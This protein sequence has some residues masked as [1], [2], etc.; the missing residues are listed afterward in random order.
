MRRRQ[1]YG[2]GSRRQQSTQDTKLEEA[3]DSEKQSN[4]T[5]QELLD[6]VPQNSIDSYTDQLPLLEIPTL[7]Q[8][9]DGPHITVS[10]KPEDEWPPP[11]YTWPADSE[12]KIK[13]AA[14]EVAVKAKDYAEDPEDLYQ[15]YRA[16]PKPRAPY[17][18]ARL[19]HQFLRHLYIVERKDESSM[20]RYL[21]VLDDV[22]NSAIPLTTAE[23]NSAISFA[24]RYVTKSTETEAE[25]ALY[26]FKEMEQLAGIKGN[27]TTFN[28]LFDVASKA[29]RFTLAE[30]IYKEMATRGLEYDRYHHVSLIHYHGL[31]SNGDGARSAYR[32]MVESNEII[33]TIVLNAMISSLIRSYEPHAAEN[34]YERMKNMHFKKGPDA[35]LPPQNF[36]TQRKITRV[37][38]TMAKISKLEPTR[39]VT[40]QAQSIIAP[41]VQTFRILVNYFAVDAGD[42]DKTA[43]YLEEMK[44]FKVPVQGAVFLALFKGFTIH[45]GIRYTHWSSHRLESVWKSYMWAVSKGW[46]D[47]YISQWTVVWALRSFAK[48]CGKA[49]TAAAWVEIKTQWQPNDLEL[50]FV[51][52]NLAAL[53]KGRDSANKKDDWLMA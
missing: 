42:F 14:F 25:A 34:I 23:W 17:L 4:L 49:R 20:L 37:L 30:M 48:C 13:L 3:E 35:P 12:T 36:L 33:D 51:L 24:A 44:W 18:S 26:M 41:D 22:K 8:P 27:S 47:V 31:K 15:L 19:R 2:A 11:N 39:R 9:S 29:G 50:E 53:M 5:K 7:Y 46:A 21:S 6:L 45:G 43:K 32:T 16:L 10:N 38:K 1:G 40:F 28:I 52:D